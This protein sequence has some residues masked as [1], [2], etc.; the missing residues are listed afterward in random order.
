MTWR[1]FGMMQKLPCVVGYRTFL[2]CLR[3][4]VFILAMKKNAHFVQFNDMA[5]L[6]LNSSD[7]GFFLHLIVRL[8]LRFWTEHPPIVSQRVDIF[9]FQNA[10]GCPTT[11]S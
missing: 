3:K 7:G 2:F 5:I 1:Y 11:R 8:L 10:P 6:V 4:C 9:T